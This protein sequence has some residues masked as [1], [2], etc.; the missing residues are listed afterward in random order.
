MP[1]DGRGIEARRPQHARAENNDG[2]RKHRY[3]G[4]L[5][6]DQ[7]A[8][9][10]KCNHDYIDENPPGKAGLPQGKDHENKDAE[11]DGDEGEAEVARPKLA[12]VHVENGSAGLLRF[13]CHGYAPEELA[14]WEWAKL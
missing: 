13:F 3:K 4:S 2:N 6:G 5:F 8:G 9:H 1:E 11:R 7:R 14:A 10:H 12:H